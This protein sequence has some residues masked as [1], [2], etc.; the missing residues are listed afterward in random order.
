MLP[1]ADAEP[2]L[3]K[4]GVPDL[5]FLLLHGDG[6]D[7]AQMQPLAEA[8]HREYPQAVVLALDAPLPLPSEAVRGFRWHTGELDAALPG[9][10]ERVRDWARHYA[11]PW[12][13]VA[14]AGFSQGG[15]LALEAVQREPALAGRVLAFGAAP[16]A[17]PEQAPQGV[18][19]HLLHGLRDTEL[20]QHRVVAAAEAWVSLGADLTADLLPGI[21]HE[22]HPK[23]IERALQQLRSFIPARLWREA[24]LQ[25]AEMDAADREAL[26]RPH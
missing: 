8:L 19:L 6:A 21:G 15:E 2:L 12:P 11:L 20:P 23:L 18:C 16:R 25:A 7:R 5:L 10:I 14:L 1:E 22:L 24:V 3:P 17:L 4:Q 9:F 26:K 13:R